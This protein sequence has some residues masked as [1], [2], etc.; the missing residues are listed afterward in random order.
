MF[1]DERLMKVA[2]AVPCWLPLMHT[3]DVFVAPLPCALGRVVA[4]AVVAG[5]STPSDPASMGAQDGL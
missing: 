3:E 5:D 4:I 2:T 1:A